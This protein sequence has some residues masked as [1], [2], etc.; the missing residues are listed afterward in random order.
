M[1]YRPSNLPRSVKMSFAGEVWGGSLVNVVSWR[2]LVA[3]SP[4]V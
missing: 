2:L 4:V 3:G 1:A